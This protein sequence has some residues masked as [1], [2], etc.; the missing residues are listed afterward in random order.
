MSASDFV[1]IL[2]TDTD[3]ASIQIYFKLEKNTRSLKFTWAEFEKLKLK[4]GF[5]QFL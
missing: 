5:S 3:E 2:W 1:E 4:C